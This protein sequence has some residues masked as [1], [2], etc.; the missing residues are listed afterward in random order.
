[1]SKKILVINAGS[2]SLKFQFIDTETEEVFAK[3]NVERINEEG[4]FLRY[5]AHGK[6]TI[7]DKPIYNHIQA[8]EMVIEALTDKEI[9]VIKNVNEIDAF[10]HRVVNV[11]ESYFDPCI[12]TK[13]NFGRFQN[14]NRFLTTSCSRSNCWN[15]SMHEHLSKN[16]KCCSF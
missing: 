12:V 9:G 8:M 3:G 6:E 10:G 15:G 7:K 5:K 2:S 14:K 4:S 13:E 16:S 1:M 11:G